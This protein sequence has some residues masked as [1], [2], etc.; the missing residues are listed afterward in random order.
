[1]DTS[2]GLTGNAHCEVCGNDT[3]QCFEV[4]LGGERHV[5]DSFECAM[6]ALSPHCGHCNS[7]IRG[8]SI[9][10]GNTIYCSYQCANDDSTRQYEARRK[11]NEQVQL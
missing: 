2:S 3:T 4:K 8:H 11:L 7:R 9:V 6:R 10:F 5:F 1:M